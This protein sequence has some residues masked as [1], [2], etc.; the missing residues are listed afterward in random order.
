MGIRELVLDQPG[1]EE[2]NVCLWSTLSP[3]LTP[4]ISSWIKDDSTQVHVL[5]SAGSQR[6]RAR[7]ASLY[8][9]DFAAML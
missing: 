3:N 1:C 2:E 8:C 6:G 9:K 5:F 4:H 7:T